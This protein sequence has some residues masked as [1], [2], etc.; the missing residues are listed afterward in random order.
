MAKEQPQKRSDR[1]VHGDREQLIRERAY[2]LWEADGATEGRADA[3]WHRA[4][5][6]M[7][8]RRAIRQSNRGATGPGRR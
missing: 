2:Q 5:W 6:R 8:S 7:R 1:E 4:C 3:Y